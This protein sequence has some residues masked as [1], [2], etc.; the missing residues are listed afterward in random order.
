MSPK[1]PPPPPG[2]SPPSAKAEPLTTKSFDVSTGIVDSP[3][4]FVIYGPGGIGKTELCSLMKHVDIKPLF[5]D[6]E[7]GTK[8]LDVARISTIDTF[9]DLRSVIQNPTATDG[10]NAIVIDS[11]T[12]AQELASEY[13]IRTVPHEKGPSYTT[14]KSIEDYGWGKGLSHIFDAC[15]LLLSDLDRA[16]GRGLH[17]VLIA[18]DCVTEVPNPRGEDWIRYE[19]RLQSPPKGKNSVRHRVKEWCDHLFYVGYD[20]NVKDGK[21]EGSGTR[22]IYPY[23]LPSHMAK[24]RSLSEEIIYEKGNPKLWKQVFQKGS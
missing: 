22:A 13:V 9:E 8:F 20:T 11:I 10:Y 21:G 15:L 17:V 24:S 5:L 16:I 12:K 4:K 18:H 14:I 1:P 3:Q 23:E 7:D 6:L 19:P 2:Q